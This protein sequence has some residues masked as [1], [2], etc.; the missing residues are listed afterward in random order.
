MLAGGFSLHSPATVASKTPNPLK[1][2]VVDPS[3]PTLGGF[4]IE[5]LKILFLEYNN[6][7]LINDTQDEGYC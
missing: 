6:T 7:F 3:S 5:E 4:Q 1:C 2:Q